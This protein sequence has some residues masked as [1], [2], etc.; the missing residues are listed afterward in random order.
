[1]ILTPQI[2][3]RPFWRYYGG[4]YRSAPMY[5]RPLDGIPIVEPFA[6]AAGY[7]VR[8]GAYRDVLLVEK[9]PKIAAIWGWLIQ[10]TP[11]DVLSLPDLEDGQTV[12]DLAIADAPK[13][14]I[15]FW[16]NNGTSQPRQT[17]SKWARRGDARW[18]G[19]GDKCRRII[20]SQVHAIRH[21]TVIGGDYSD[22]PDIAATWFVDPPYSTPAGDYYKHGNRGIDFE[23]LGQWC[24]SRSGLAIA[25]DQSPADWLDF[26]PLADVKSTLGKSREL[27]WTNRTRP[28][29][30]D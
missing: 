14:L 26:R 13:W 27:I 3:M 11:D 28:F 10:A 9:D 12:D 15:G 5:P 8:F 24:R 30:G 1:M 22:C 29:P 18:F 25:C 20:A 16:M 4:K 21:W 17:P 6:G 23:H 7:S 19:W 2:T